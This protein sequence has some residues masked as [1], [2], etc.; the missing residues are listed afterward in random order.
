[1]TVSSAVATIDF[2]SI[3]ATYTDLEL[4]VSG[5]RTSSGTSKEL[6][7]LLNNDTAGHYYRSEIEWGPTG[8]QLSGAG[9]ESAAR[10]IANVPAT[11]VANWLCTGRIFLPNYLGTFSKAILAHLVDNAGIFGV[12]MGSVKSSFWNQ[13]TAI[14]RVTL[15]LASSTFDKGSA[16]L[17]GRN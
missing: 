12:P 13:T 11:A 2:S 15:Q 10:F 6:Q 7:L 5:L 1:V 14:N 8:S 17:Y 4:V 3:P 16:W 9:S